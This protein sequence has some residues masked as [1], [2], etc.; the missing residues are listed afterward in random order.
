[1]FSGCTSLST[2]P[3]LPATQLAPYCYMNMFNG[4]NQLNYV[5]MMATDISS[6]GNLTVITWLYRVAPTGTFVKNSAATW[7]ESKVIPSGWTVQ[8]AEM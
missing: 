7:D 6:F 5:K 1:M 8:T 2:A 3:A 4:C